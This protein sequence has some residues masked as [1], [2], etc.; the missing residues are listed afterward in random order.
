MLSET[1]PTCTELLAP[2]VGE[3]AAGPAAGRAAAGVHSRPGPER[4][5]RLFGLEGANF[6]PS[7]RFLSPLPSRN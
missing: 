5:A 3:A 6:Q 2:V 7:H 4:H 1:F